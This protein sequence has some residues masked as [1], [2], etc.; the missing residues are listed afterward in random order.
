M[1]LLQQCL[2]FL[3]VALFYLSLY[4]KFRISET[5]NLI[6]FIINSFV[7]FSAFKMIKVN[8]HSS[9][10]ERASNYC[11]IAFYFV[12]V[13]TFCLICVFNLTTIDRIFKEGIK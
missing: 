5:S 10:N 1:L 2:V 12:I 7:S 13:F 8:K 3:S 4:F 6:T 9:K 11:L